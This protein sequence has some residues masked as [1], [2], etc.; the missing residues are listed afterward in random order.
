MAPPLPSAEQLSN[1]VQSRDN[2]DDPSSVSEIAPPFPLKRVDL[3][4]VNL[5]YEEELPAIESVPPLSSVPLTPLLPPLLERSVNA[6]VV[7]VTLG[8][9][10]KVMTDVPIDA[11]LPLVSDAKF[12]LSSVSVPPLTENTG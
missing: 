1:A 3:Q 7:S 2:A 4:L 10:L 9:P 6:Q 5:A 8:D 11:A 12:T